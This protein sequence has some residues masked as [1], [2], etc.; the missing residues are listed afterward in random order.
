[1]NKEKCNDL[2]AIICNYRSGEIAPLTSAHVEKWVSQFDEQVQDSILEE[3]IYIFSKWYYTYEDI[4][5]KFLGKIPEILQK[6]YNFA[7]VQETLG[8]VSFTKVQ[9]EGQSQKKLIAELIQI[10]QKQ[11]GINLVT[12]IDSSISHYAY[13]DDGFYS[14]SRARKDLKK[15]ACQ[16][17]AGDTLDVFYI[18]V[19]TSGVLYSMDEFKKIQTECG[20]DIHLHKLLIADNERREHE[21][22]K[23]VVWWLKSQTCLWPSSTS[24]ADPDVA[25]FYEYLKTIGSNYEKFPY[26][27]SH[28]VNDQGV[29]SSEDRRSLVEHEFLKKGIQIFKDYQAKYNDAKGMY[30]LGYN[31]WPSFGFGILFATEFNVPN[32]APLV[33]WADTNWY[34]LLPRRK[35]NQEDLSHVRQNVA[36]T[37][38]ASYGSAYNICPD[39]GNFFGLD[40]D[41]GNGFCINCA[42]NH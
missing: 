19:C 12:N 42:W 7:S 32:N 38:K 40:E 14:G 18:V 36:Y 11:Y 22:E 8:S 1:M 6:E 9:S 25:S 29:F 30:P 41:G 33:I 2:A 35:N 13:I 5:N 31:L 23:G 34:P 4:V 20:I 37:E 3:M 15:L 10:I 27:K 26:R 39:C 24:E 16:L 17:K 28:W 21:D